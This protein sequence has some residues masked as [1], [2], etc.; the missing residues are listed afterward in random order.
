MDESTAPATKK[1]R[2]DGSGLSHSD[3]VASE[4]NNLYRQ[5]NEPSFTADKLQPLT[6]FVEVIGGVQSF[7]G[8]KDSVVLLLDTLDR[9]VHCTGASVGQSDIT[10]LQQLLMSVIGGLADR[11]VCCPPS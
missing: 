9:V 4:A 10:Y 5:H 7:S 8:S 2:L 11:L 1:A 6:L 3:V